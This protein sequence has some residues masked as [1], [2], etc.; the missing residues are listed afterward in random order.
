MLEV[1]DKEKPEEMCDRYIDIIQRYLINKSITA[2]GFLKNDLQE[3]NVKSLIYVSYV[4]EDFPL[5]PKL[6]Q[7]IRLLTSIRGKGGN[8]IKRNYYNQLVEF[9]ALYVLTKMMGF[10]FVDF[11]MTSN[12]QYAQPNKN[13]DLCLEKN[14]RLY[15]ADAKDLSGE[16][17]STTE[18]ED[19]NGNKY[20]HYTPA[21]PEVLEG[22]LK[23]YIAEADKKGSDFLIAHIPTWNLFDAEIPNLQKFN[24]KISKEIV[25]NE[26]KF[27]WNIPNAMIDKVIFIKAFGFWEIEITK[28]NTF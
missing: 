18:G 7:K 12:K 4:I 5:N 14:N 13:C 19:D 26:G 16:I 27:L 15:F 17:M 9:H 6:E 22:W 24:Q 21:I 10:N 2:E 3:R 23:G 11:D 1:Q 20:E 25:L 28:S 8:D